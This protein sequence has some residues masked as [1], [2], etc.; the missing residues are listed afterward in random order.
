[1]RMLDNVVDIN[2][3]PTPE[4]ERSNLRHR[5]VGLGLMGFQDVLFMLR[6]PFHSTAAIRFA[7]ETMELISYNAIL[8]SSR[9]SEERGRYATYPGSKWDRGIFPVDTIDLLEAE[10]GLPVS[11]YR[12]S[13]LDW[14][15]VRKHVAVHGM[16]NSNVTAVAPTATISNIAGCYPCIEPIYKNLYVKANMS[17]EFIIMNRYLVGNLKARGLWNSQMLEQLKYYD[18]S[19]ERIEG[20]SAELK[21]LYKEAFEIDP[22]H[23]IEITAARGKW[24]DQSQSHNVFMRGTSGKKLHDVYMAAW[25]TGLKT[26]YYLR[27]LAAIQIENLPWMPAGSATH[28][29]ATSLKSIHQPRKPQSP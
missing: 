19:L 10:R 2:F 15:E 14:N 16:R 22:V 5:P 20:V 4:A 8:A 24:I 3:Y 25:E 21:N 26:T 23:L 13:K 17:G 27:T 11:V 18:G 12:N 7:D 1:M 29:S 6:I 28:R 9:L